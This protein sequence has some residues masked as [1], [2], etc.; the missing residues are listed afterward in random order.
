MLGCCASVGK[1]GCKVTIKELTLQILGAP[2]L[3][4]SEVSLGKALNPKLLPME[5]AVPCM[6]GAI[7]W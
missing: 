3:R 7:H 2:T 4:M 1:V 6:A 5:L